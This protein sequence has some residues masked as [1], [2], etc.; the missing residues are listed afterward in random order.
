MA[1]AGRMAA[2]VVACD[3]AMIAV[4]D[5]SHSSFL[6]FMVACGVILVFWVVRVVRSRLVR[7][8][9]HPVRVVNERTRHWL[10]AAY[11]A[12]ALVGAAFVN[13]VWDGAFALY[14]VNLTIVWVE[15]RVW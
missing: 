11:F 8:R 3:L 4:W 1:L 6:Q 9:E 10:T 5:A 2:I 7:R 15:F 12:A 14:E 13:G